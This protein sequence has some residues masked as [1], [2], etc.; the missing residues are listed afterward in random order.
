MDR[1]IDSGFRRRQRIRKTALALGAVAMIGAAYF[2]G[3]HFIRPSVARD[4][5]RTARVEKGPVEAVI[6]A[7]GTV[8][9]EIEQVLSSP[10]NARVLKILKRPGSVLSKGDPIFELDLNESKLA[11]EK[12]NRQ[13]DLKRN[14]QTEVKLDL[15]NRLTTLQSQWKIKNLECK[16]ALAASE[17]NRALFQKG[18]ISEERLLET[19]LIEQRVGYELTQIE[20]SIQNAQQMTEIQLEGLALEMKT[21][22]DEREE[23]WRRLELATTKS[24]RNGVLTWVVS[25]EGATVTKGEVLARIADLS[26]Y[27]VEGRVSDVHA[28]RLGVGLPTR[29]RIDE[30]HLAGHISRINPKIDEGVITFIVDLDEK[31]SPLLRSNLR[32]EVLVITDRKDRVLNV[33]KGPFANAEGIRDVFVIHGDAAV[34][35]EARFGI[36]GA[37]SYEVV[38]GLF[39]GDEVIISDTDDFIHMKGLKVK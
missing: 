35:T 1:E 19:E 21:L 14:R 34:R 27:R 38:E 17:R 4:R 33:K 32:V 16:S 12:L 7:E 20:D 18:S 8:V 3:T 26:T 24:D 39:E 28:G 25:E 37:E 29:V 13:I 15:E 10:V 6:T 36:A 2:W 9:P 5:I 31:S 30:S 23:A 11:V 22:E